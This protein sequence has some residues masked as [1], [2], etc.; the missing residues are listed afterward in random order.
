MERVT[1]LLDTNAVADYINGFEPTTGRIK[2]A[3]REGH[4]L[5]LCRPV[6]YEVL[7][8]LLKTKADRKRRVFEEQFAPQLVAVALIDG[9]WQQ[10]A[11]FWAD[12]VNAGRQ[13]AD[14]DLL[15]AAITRRIHGVLVS[16]DADFDALPVTREDWRVI[17]ESGS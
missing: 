2:Q 16:A 9:D 7:R 11:R 10:A 17:K 15:I 1:Y 14:T 6:Y 8:G 5:C 3:I 13:L 4:L 12:A